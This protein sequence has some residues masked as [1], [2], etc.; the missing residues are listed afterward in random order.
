MLRAVRVTAAGLALATGCDES[1][2]EYSPPAPARLEAVTSVNVTAPAGTS[3]TPAP[4][5][6]VLDPSGN[7]VPAVPIQFRIDEGPLP[8]VIVPTNHAGTATI[9]SW[10]LTTRV[11]TQTVTATAF[12][13]PPVVF[14]ATATPRE[15]PIDSACPSGDWC[16]AGPLLAFVR[17]DAIFATNLVDTGVVRITRGG[18]ARDRAPVWSPDRSRLAFRRWVQSAPWPNEYLC[19]ARFDGSATRCAN[20]LVR[21]RAS[22][23]P[24]GAELAF[25]GSTRE[26]AIGRPSR[27]R[28]YALRTD[29]MATVRV[30]AEDIGQ[31]CSTPDVSWSPSGNSIALTSVAP[32]ECRSIGIINADGTNL[33]VITR[34]H[35]GDKES[36]FLMELD[37][38]PDGQKLA[39]GVVRFEDCW[40][41]CDTAIGVINADGTGFRIVEVASWREG[42]AVADPVW[43]PDGSRIAYTRIRGC[44]DGTCSVIDVSFIGADGS[45]GGTIVSNAQMPSWR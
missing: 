10:T 21:G 6:R 14:T 25:F 35:L 39:V 37:W 3:V 38:S 8:D 45:A 36:D 43:S 17:D 44:S 9:G 13:L 32:Y 26:D 7:P 33:R 30:I 19:V 23:S 11:G 18:D 1:P 28:L 41:A 12:G 40:D 31:G 16:S 15:I 2:T 42:D 24:D 22:W 34:D 5:V 29:D 20:I 27:V 4:V